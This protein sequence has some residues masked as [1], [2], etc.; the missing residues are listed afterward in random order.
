MLD[1]ILV[2]DSKLVNSNVFIDSLEAE[3]RGHYKA[4]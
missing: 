4:S 3:A 2:E 1:F